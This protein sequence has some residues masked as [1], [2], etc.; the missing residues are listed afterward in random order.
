MDVL[1]CLLGHP[2]SQMGTISD[3]GIVNI[4]VSDSVSRNDSTSRV[5]VF[6]L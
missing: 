4:R 5:L 1:H 2:M 6:I 3:C